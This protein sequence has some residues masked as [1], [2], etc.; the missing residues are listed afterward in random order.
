MPRAASCCASSESCGPWRV[1]RSKERSPFSSSAQ[2]PSHWPVTGSTVPVPTTRV[3]TRALPPRVLR[4]KPVVNSLTVDAG[5]SGRSSATLQ[6]MRPVWSEMAMPHSPGAR[7]LARLYQESSERCTSASPCARGHGRQ[8]RQPAHQ[9]EQ[10]EHG[11][12]QWARRAKE[13]RHWGTAW[14]W[15]GS[16]WGP[17]TRE[18]VARTVPGGPA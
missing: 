17:S 1:A 3:A 4:A 14:L 13:T 9:G 7:R 10:A 11:A 6:M 18:G 5:R 15:L 8:H 16:G 12:K 2:V